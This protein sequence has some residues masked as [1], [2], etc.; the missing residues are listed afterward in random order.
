VQSLTVVTDSHVYIGDVLVPV[1]H[2]GGFMCQPD[3]CLRSSKRGPEVKV[4]SPILYP[5]NN[6]NGSPSTVSTC[7]KYAYLGTKMDGPKRKSNQFGTILT[8]STILPT[9]VCGAS[10]P[11]GNEG[12]IDNSRTR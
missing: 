4:P 7:T 8:H 2:R 9:G 6:V 3:P 1:A 11:W 5:F 12:R 10:R